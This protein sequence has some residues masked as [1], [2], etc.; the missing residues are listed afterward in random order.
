MMSVKWKGNWKKR[1]E[2]TSCSH[3]SSGALK[4]L[5]SITLILLISVRDVGMRASITVRTIASFYRPE[6][7]HTVCAHYCILIN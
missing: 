5:F 7:K 3:G 6:I 1:G 4:T 2:G